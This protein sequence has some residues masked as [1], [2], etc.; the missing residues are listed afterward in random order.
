[1]L[2]DYIM[3]KAH[4]VR[5]SGPFPPQALIGTLQAIEC[6]L[7]KA[8]SQKGNRF[9][10]KTLQ[11]LSVVLLNKSPACL[12]ILSANL[13][14]I[15]PSPASAARYRNKLKSN[16]NTDIT[17]RCGIFNI[18]SAYRNVCADLGWITSDGRPGPMQLCMDSSR[19]RELVKPSTSRHVVIGLAAT[20]VDDEWMFEY[21]YGDLV[22]DFVS[23]FKKTPKAGYALLGLLC[24]LGPNLPPV[25]ICVIPHN[26]KFTKEDLQEWYQLMQKQWTDADLPVIQLSTDCEQKNLNLMESILTQSS[27]GETDEKIGLHIPGWFLF[28]NPSHGDLPMNVGL[29][30]KHGLRT[31]RTQLLHYHKILVTP[32]GLATMQHYIH[33]ADVDGAHMYPSMWDSSDRTNHEAAVEAAQEYNIRALYTAGTMRNLELEDGSYTLPQQHMATVVHMHINKMLY[34][35]YANKTMPIYDRVVKCGLVFM[36]AYGWRTWLLLSKEY[37]INKNF[38]SSPYIKFL[39]IQCQS[40]VNRLLIHMQ[41]FRGLPFYPAVDGSDQCEKGFRDIKGKSGICSIKDVCDNLSNLVAVSCIRTQDTELKFPDDKKKESVKLDMQVFHDLPAT[42]SAVHNAFCAGQKRG[43][44]LLKLLQM[45]DTLESAG[46]LQTPLIPQWSI[47]S[48]L[49]QHTTQND[50]ESDEEEVDHPDDIQETENELLVALTDVAKTPAP[51]HQIRSAAKPGPSFL[52]SEG[53]GDKKRKMNDTETANSQP[54]MQGTISKTSSSNSKGTVMQQIC[55]LQCEINCLIGNTIIPDE[56]YRKRAQ[57]LCI[58]ASNSNE[59]HLLNDVLE[60]LQ[61]LQDLVPESYCARTSVSACS[62]NKDQGVYVHDGK[63]NL[64]HPATACATLSRKGELLYPGAG[65]LLKWKMAQDFLKRVQVPEVIGNIKPGRPIAYLTNA[66]EW[67]IGCTEQIIIRRG[68]SFV[69]TQAT[70]QREKDCFI[71]V[72]RLLPCKEKKEVAFS[73]KYHFVPMEAV[74]MVPVKLLKH[75]TCD[76]VFIINDK[77]HCKLNGYTSRQQGVVWNQ[78]IVRKGEI[79]NYKNIYT[80]TNYQHHYGAGTLKELTV[81]QLKAYLK[82][83]KLVSSG[84]KQV[85]VKKVELSLRKRRE[86]KPSVRIK[87]RLNQYAAETKPLITQP[88]KTVSASYHQA[89]PKFEQGLYPLQAGTQCC[90]MAFSYQS[91]LNASNW[92]TGDLNFI[93]EYGDELHTTVER[94]H[95]NYAEPVGMPRSISMLAR[96]ITIEL[97]EECNGDVY[98]TEDSAENLQ[99]SLPTAIMKALFRTSGC[100]TTYKGYTVGVMQT[101]TGIRLFDPHA[102][103]TDGAPLDVGVAVLLCLQDVAELVTYIRNFVMRGQEAK[104]KGRTAASQYQITPVTTSC[105]A[106]SPVSGSPDCCVVYI[107]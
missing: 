83:E 48:Q 82:H 87:F 92:D 46:H 81:V 5:G 95:R 26:N 85:L 29:D 80:D 89:S 104:I 36:V 74:L 19:F 53:D 41:H 86:E 96:N 97:G 16:L 37:T 50:I 88:G 18:S 49:A 90:S 79:I 59:R 66:K 45:H 43:L 78:P 62:K 31:G 51:D 3:S 47:T 13:P 76:K 32:V 55:K 107:Q 24:A 40:F 23:L 42:A 30:P 12:D 84:S 101:S 21:P 77:D 20:K 100:L 10:N 98:Q 17:G 64:V 39:L 44:T 4:L 57:N 38:Y 35:V 71:V 33:S 75:P 52:E 28:L 94:D 22:S 6:N 11:D 2:S 14:G 54:S 15:I 27:P 58:Q 9:V 69:L 73:N 63:G 25:P 103:S 65:R 68:H 7:L 56:Q 99:W 67:E 93:L 1:M 106:E 60:E 61:V 34:D 72:N 105:A 91:I 70:S 8:K 102:R